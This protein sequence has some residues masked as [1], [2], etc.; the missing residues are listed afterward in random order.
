M[1][2]KI[3]AAVG[4]IMALSLAAFGYSPGFTVGADLDVNTPVLDTYLMLETGSSNHN[5]DLT[6]GTGD[7]V[8]IS[9]RFG[10]ID[11]N[12]FIGYA[13]ISADDFGIRTSTTIAGLSTGINLALS[14]YSEWATNV[15]ITD[16][17][18]YVRAEVFDLLPDLLVQFGFYGQLDLVKDGTAFDFG[19]VVGGTIKLPW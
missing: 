15:A 12:Y 5:F 17:D 11:A 16:L 3:F 13:Q 6:V 4:L 1:K 9:D 10:W 7:I 18:M 8:D 14:K 2:K 19:G